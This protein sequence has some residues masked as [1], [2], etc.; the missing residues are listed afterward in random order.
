M[1]GGW[2][3]GVC[4]SCPRGSKQGQRQKDSG[5]KTGGLG[6]GDRRTEAGRQEDRGRETGGQGQGDRRTGAG[7]QEDGAG[8]QE[9]RGRETGGQRQGY[10]RTGAGRQEG[11]GRDRLDSVESQAAAR[12]DAIG[13]RSLEGS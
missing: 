8:S 1:S 7:K 10:R 11:A 5:R 12:P 2:S 4:L 9:D 3:R 13:H 6:Q